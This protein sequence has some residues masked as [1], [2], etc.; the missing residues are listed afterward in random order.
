M[1]PTCGL[2]VQF[3]VTSAAGLDGAS[4]A[5]PTCTWTF[6]D[7][8]TATG[9]TGVQPLAA[10][11]RTG[12]VVVTDPSSGCSDIVTTAPVTVYPPLSVTADLVGS[13]DGSFTYAA[14]GSGGSGAFSYLWSF[15]GGGPVSVSSSSA[16]AGSVTVGATPA[17]YSGTV[18]L[19]DARPD[20][21]SCP[22]T[23]TDETMVFSPM[24]VNLAL[25][26]AAQACPTMADDGVRY[27]AVISGGSGN[28]SVVW[29]GAACSGTSCV[30]NPADGTFCDTQSF[31]A[32]V[33]DDSGLC[34]A[35]TSET[36]TYSKITMVNVTDN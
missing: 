28:Y 30:I 21:L 7:G 6:D 15:S 27:D 8:S 22:A 9:C 16:P 1:H 18:S 33:S 23:A 29:N 32:T 5:N 20:G 19:I 13:C 2:D 35:V 4:I 31:S 36:E 26:G 10:G 34:P 12:T 3:A 11:A 14:V 24:H 17:S 25:S